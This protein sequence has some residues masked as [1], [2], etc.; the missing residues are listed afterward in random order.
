[1][2]EKEGARITV[3]I[4]KGNYNSNKK[5]SKTVQ[6]ITSARY[7]YNS[8]NSRKTIIIVNKQSGTIRSHDQGSL[9]KAPRVQLSVYHSF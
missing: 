7:S 6:V 3:V 5:K 4:T 8:N 9:F 2:C 1:M